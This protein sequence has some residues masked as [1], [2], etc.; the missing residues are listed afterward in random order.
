MRRDVVCRA[1]KVPSSCDYDRQ[2]GGGMTCKIAVVLQ[3][4]VVITALSSFVPPNLWLKNC[5]LF[6]IQ[7]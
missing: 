1:G 6:L 4:S 7:L 5:D 2:A 3:Y